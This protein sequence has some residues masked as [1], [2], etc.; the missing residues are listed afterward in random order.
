MPARREELEQIVRTLESWE[1]GSASEGERRAA[2]WIAGRLRELG[3]QP[4]VEAE[5]A[6]GGYWWPLGLLSGIAA[7]A[8]LA[9]GGERGRRGKRRLGGHAARTLAGAFAAFGIWDELGLWRGHW[10]RRLLP[11]RE[12]HNVHAYGGDES[13]DR[14]VAI[15]AHHDA[16]H[17][18]AIFDFGLI[19]WYGRTFPDL[20]EKGRK[21]PGLNWLTFLAPVVVAVGS[22]LG[23]KRL[24]RIGGVMNLGGAL[25]FADV[26]RSAVVPGANDNL[27]AVAVVLEVARALRDEPVEGVKV[28]FLSNG[29]EESFEEGMAGFMRTHEHELPR[30]RTD[31]IVLDT[32][33]SPRLILLEGEG[34]LLT[35]PYDEPLKEEIAAAAAEIGVPII[36]E[37][38]LS[39]ATDSLIALRKGYRTAT[40]ASFDELKLPTNYHQPSDV[41]DNLH[42]DTVEAAANVTEAAI[43]RLARRG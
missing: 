14:I 2:E 37:H 15:V 36:R 40:I 31:F 23:S 8:G 16:A 4:K 17:T 42:W 3:Y 26:G 25:T 12:T 27:S 7:A 39:F 24:R 30:D 10:T 6:H 28:L 11:K 34:M 35:R 20:L 43:R 9:P 29:A 41:A 18:G 1:R 13:A 32:V 22:L 5:P 19:R 33:G 21:W 38:W